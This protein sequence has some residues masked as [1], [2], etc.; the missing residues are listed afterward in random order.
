MYTQTH[1]PDFFLFYRN[2]ILI[3][4]RRYLNLGQIIHHC[5][6]SHDG[7]DAQ[8]PGVDHA[9]TQIFDLPAQAQFI[10]ALDSFQIHCFIHGK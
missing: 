1:K 10:P 7:L 4:C 9:D 8:L 2:L 5:I 3:Q 6:K